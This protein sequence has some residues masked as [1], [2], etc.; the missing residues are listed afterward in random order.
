MPTDRNY[1]LV[2]V[3]LVMERFT[4]DGENIEQP[5]AVYSTRTLADAKVRDM[6]KTYTYVRELYMDDTGIILQE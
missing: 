5:V 3:Y 6:W 2:R 4:Y 1:G